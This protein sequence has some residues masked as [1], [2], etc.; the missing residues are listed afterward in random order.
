M[1]DKKTSMVFDCKV[2][3]RGKRVPLTLNGTVVG[4]AYEDGGQ[5]MALVS[6]D[7]IPE[8]LKKM[9]ADG[10]GT[11]GHGFSVSVQSE[12]E[13]VKANLVVGPAQDPYPECSKMSAAHEESLALSRFVDW[14]NT[15]GISFCRFNDEVNQ[16]FPIQEGYEQLFL[17]YFGIDPAKVEAERQAMLEVQRKLNREKEPKQGA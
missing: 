2:A 13:P 8:H 6:D 17:S 15:S 3:S 7:M 5:W 16:W 9:L 11:V 10:K 1:S 4:E 14:C 12:I